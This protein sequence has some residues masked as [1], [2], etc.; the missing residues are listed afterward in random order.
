[1]S[2]TTPKNRLS[3][4]VIGAGPIGLATA[5]ALTREGH[6]VTVLERHAS[7]QAPGSAL[8]VQ[9]AANKCLQH[10]GAL[11]TLERNSTATNRMVWYSYKDCEPMVVQRLSENTMMP[12]CSSTRPLVQ[13]SLYDVAL[14]AGIK[15]IF[16]K[17]VE[18]VQDGD[19]AKNPV[20]WTQDGEEWTA[21]LIVGA[22]GMY[23]WTT[24]PHLTHGTLHQ[25]D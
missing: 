3:I 15:M 21:D 24:S 14:E 11:E 5:I 8:M 6:S 7:L 20:V 22:D 23:I 17:A 2:T 25:L 10:M 13:K 4:L 1:M 18:R 12:N 9:P 16:G 19:G